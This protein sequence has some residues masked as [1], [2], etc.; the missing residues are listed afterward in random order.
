MPPAEHQPGS[1][2]M[3]ASRA[4]IW[5]LWSLHEATEDPT[6]FG[7]QMIRSPTTQTDLS[8]NSSHRPEDKSSS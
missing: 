7:D 3:R 8:F 4:A 5:Y 2:D 1:G 6:L